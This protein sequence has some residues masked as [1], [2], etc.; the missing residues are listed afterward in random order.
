M[1]FLDPNPGFSDPGW[2]WVK[3]STPTNQWSRAPLVD[4]DSGPKPPPVDD[5]ENLFFFV[6]KTLFVAMLLTWYDAKTLFV[7]MLPPI[8]GLLPGILHAFMCM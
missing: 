6:W 7:G 3:F 5:D 2:R 4:D 1:A 8:V